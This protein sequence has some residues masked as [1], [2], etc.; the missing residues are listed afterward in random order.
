[1]DSLSGQA[2]GDQR[3]SHLRPRAKRSGG[4]PQDDF[5]PRIELRQHGEITILPASGAGHDPRC[6]FQLDHNVDGV[7]PVGVLKQ[8]AED[9]R[10][11]VIGQVAVYP[12]AAGAE[13]AF[14]VERQHISGD[15]FD[16]G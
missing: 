8:S 16:V 5:R 13:D 3:R 4:N 12:E 2:Q 9:G 14:Q 10:G 6:Y 1:M 7:D 15:H 11:D